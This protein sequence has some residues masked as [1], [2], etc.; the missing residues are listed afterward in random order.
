MLQLKLAAVFPLKE[1]DD[2]L[3]VVKNLEIKVNLT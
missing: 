2:D 3:P 1:V